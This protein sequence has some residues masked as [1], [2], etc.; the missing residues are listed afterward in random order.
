MS[1]EDYNLD[2]RSL[3]VLKQ[4]NI[5]TPTPVQAGAIPLALE[6]KDVMAVAQTGTG[7]T[8]G[9]VLPSLTRLAAG[10]LTKNMM[11]VLVPTRELCTQVEAVVND[12]GKAMGI[13]STPVYG[14]VSFDRQLKILRSGVHVIVATPGRLL[15]HMSRGKLRF[16]SLEI[17]VLD[18]ADRMLD[19]G[20]LPDIQRIL[21]KLPDQRQ[22]LMFSATFPREIGRMAE[23]LMNEPERITVGTIARPVDTVRQF[24]YPVKPEAKTRLLVQLLEEMEPTSTLIFLRTKSRTERLA[25]ALKKKG[26]KI[27][28]IHGDRSQS[29]RQQALDGFR[30]GRY[31][32]LVATDVAAR[33]L[34]ID[35]VSHVFNY[36]IPLSADDYI[37][38]IGRTARA[39]AEGDAITFV[40]PA[41]IMPLG[42]I[43]R[44]LEHLI[45]RI[46]VDG[47]PKVLS[48]F[49]PAGAK[50]TGPGQRRRPGRRML[51]RR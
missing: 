21:R 6:G 14:G 34:D 3:H 51:R 20:F 32:V 23:R 35:G 43:E 47:A 37:H 27:A 42:A 17:L 44:T 9:F 16:D 28:Q 39:E 1:F 45:P 30:S 19:M 13:R 22:T 12:I 4:Q 38:R 18:E 50:R 40:S 29:Q 10:K 7:K 48:I 11:L 8:L 26:H 15:D 5:V 33:G 2:P 31:K 25:H 49:K 46:E 36:D 24:L 41:E